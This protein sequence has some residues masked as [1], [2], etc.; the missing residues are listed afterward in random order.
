MC[1]EKKNCWEYMKCGCEPGGHKAKTM[2]VCP[3]AKEGECAHANDGKNYGRF[4]WTI[5]G[6]FCKG[7]NDGTFSDKFTS[8]LN[9]PF[10]LEVEKQEGRLFQL[11][12]D[13]KKT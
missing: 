4:C 12:P 6:T 1:N 10:Y 13:K 9:C 8:C 7:T 11:L 3:A 2:G 5:A